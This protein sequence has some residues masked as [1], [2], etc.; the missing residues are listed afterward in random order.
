LVCVLIAIGS[1]SECIAWAWAKS[2]LANGCFGDLHRNATLNLTHLRTKAASVCLTSALTRELSQ[3]PRSRKML[4]AHGD[5]GNGY[6][7]DSHGNWFRDRG[8]KVGLNHCSSHGLRKAGARRL[9]EHGATEW[10]VVAFL[11]HE[12]PREASR[13]VAAANRMKLTTSGMARLEPKQEQDLS[14]LGERLDKG[15]S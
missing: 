2:A 11:A 14:N 10:E 1:V 9:V 6:S 8:R 13:Y 15:A 3:L 4:L 12:T 7:P 5:H